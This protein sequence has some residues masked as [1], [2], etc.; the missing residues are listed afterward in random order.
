MLQT[1]VAKKGLYKPLYIAK[2]EPKIP[3]QYIY[4]YNKRATT[5]NTGNTQAKK[6]GEMANNRGE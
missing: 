6:R 2:R 3:K 5:P 1:A 4:I